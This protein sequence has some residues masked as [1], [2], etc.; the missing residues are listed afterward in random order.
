M[1]R[2]LVKQYA[3]KLSTERGAKVTMIE[4]ENEIVR[5][6]QKVA[7]MIAP[8]YRFGYLSNEDM[9]QE[10]VYEALIAIE[11]G[12]YDVTRP[13]ENFMHVHIH[14]RLYNY[15]RKHYQRLEAPCKCCDPYDPPAYPCQKWLDWSARNSTKQNLMRPLDMSNIADESEQNMR[16]DSEVVDDTIA[17]ELRTMLDRELPVD[18]RRDYL[19]M[20]DGKVIPKVRRQRVRDAV[21]EIT[22]EK[23][24]IDAISF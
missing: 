2:N 13:L 14:H 18:L 6:I 17:S 10:G 3:T 23:G 8:S 21:I 1:N 24:Y 7:R 19:Q 11:K 5:T 20:L 9:E 15:R 22:H 16:E 4:A 12:D